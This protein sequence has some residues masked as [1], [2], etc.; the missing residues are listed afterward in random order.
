M[1]HA[2]VAAGLLL[3]LAV[4]GVQAAEGKDGNYP[5]RPIRL[6]IPFVPGGPSD[7][8]SRLM[9]GRLSEALGQQVVPDNRGSAGGIVGFELGAKANPDGY[10]LLMA[11]YSGYTIN[12][13]VYKSLPYDP[14]KDLQPITQL[15]VGGNII[16]INN[17]VNAKSV[18]ELIALAKTM[19]G[20]MN[21]ASTGAGPLFATERFKKEAGINFVNIPYKGTGQAVIAILSNEVQMFVMNPLIAVPNIKGGK[22][23]ALAVTSLKRN[24]VLP[25]LPTVSESA[26]PGFENVTW[27]SFAFPAKTP[28][29]VLKR[30]HE[31]IVKVLMT[32]AVRDA[33][34]QQGLEPVGNTPD[35]L[36]AR[37]RKEYAEY[38]K[39]VKEI[40]YEPQ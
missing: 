23:R 3:A 27:H 38:A 13:H 6:V 40:G 4:P 25:D 24:P 8:L 31:E 37:I 34:I 11:A 21:F 10:T 16:V 14:L 22:V 35:E 32:P 29:P 18:K 28:K 1:H 39:L 30:M 17:A 12:P 19:P 2:I 36:S 7:T 15:T 9:G 26:L 5:N 20:K 33:I